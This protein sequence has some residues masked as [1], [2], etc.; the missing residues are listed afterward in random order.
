M[1][2]GFIIA[3]R[4][5]IIQERLFKPLL[6]IIMQESMKLEFQIT[7]NMTFHPF[8]KLVKCSTMY[9]WVMWVNISSLI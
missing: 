6:H 7:L 9:I 3:Q 2:H 4:Q 8:L 1:S 5:D